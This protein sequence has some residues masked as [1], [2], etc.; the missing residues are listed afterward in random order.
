[1]PDEILGDSYSIIRETLR[2]F[3][4]SKSE[5]DEYAKKLDPTLRSVM[6]KCFAECRDNGFFGPH[7]GSD[8]EIKFAQS[9]EMRQGRGEVYR[10]EMH[11]AD[12][13]MEI[14]RV[15]KEFL[16]PNMKIIERIR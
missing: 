14:K 8:G 10:V 5:W 11:G 4:K 6:A 16:R 15:A 1:M 9:V 13:T 3:S 12:G 7:I 2:N